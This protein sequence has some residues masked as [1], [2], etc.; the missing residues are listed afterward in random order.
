MRNKMIWFHYP[1]HLRKAQIEN[2]DGSKDCLE[3]TTTGPFIHYD[4]K[5]NGIVI[6]EESDS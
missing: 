4:E 1:Q 3:E 5:A 6:S 2:I